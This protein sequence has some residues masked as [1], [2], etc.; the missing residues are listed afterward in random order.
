MLGSVRCSGVIDIC[1]LLSHIIDLWLICIMESFFSLN[2][3]LLII[4]G[5]LLGRYFNRRLEE[6]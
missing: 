4:E 3:L 5:E 2:L 1:W 6:I